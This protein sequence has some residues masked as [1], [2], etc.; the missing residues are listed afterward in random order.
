MLA[1]YDHHSH[2]NDDHPSHLGCTGPLSTEPGTGVADEGGE[3]LVEGEAGHQAQHLIIIFLSMVRMIIL[4]ILRRR[5]TIIIA[6]AIMRTK[7][8]NMNTK[9]IKPAKKT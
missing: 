9:E 1:Q 2:K 4:I 3:L 5:I 8:S 7:I 6:I